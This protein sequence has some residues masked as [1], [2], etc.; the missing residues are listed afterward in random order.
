MNPVKFS[1]LKL[2]PSLLKAV[3]EEGYTAP[4]PIQEK[5]IPPAL[6]GR[7]PWAHSLSIIVHPAPV[8]KRQ[9]A[10]EPL[11]PA[12]SAAIQLST[13]AGFTWT[14]QCL[15]WGKPASRA[16]WTAWAVAWV[17]LRVSSPLARIST[18]T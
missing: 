8:R 3:E 13:R 1:D 12:R 11:A 4:S 16:S 18:S 5:A 14:M 15:T 10:P 17:S 9:K 2:M 6:A 7:G